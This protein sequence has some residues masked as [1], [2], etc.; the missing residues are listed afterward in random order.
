MTRGKMLKYL[1]FNLGKRNSL[2]KLP[3]AQGRLFG[4]KMG[5]NFA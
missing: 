4:V 2:S 5:V 1:F 3:A